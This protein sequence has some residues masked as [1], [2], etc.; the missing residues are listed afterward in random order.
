MGAYHTLDLEM[1]RKFTL[2]KHEWD[3]IALDRI[4]KIWFDT[5]L[6][7]SFVEHL[8]QEEVTGF[9]ISHSIPN[10]MLRLALINILTN[11]DKLGKFLIKQNCLNS[12]DFLV[13]MIT[14]NC[15]IF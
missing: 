2:G 15:I 3:S 4:G 8:F 5:V 13:V 7:A 11:L 1:N 12:S 14:L 10:Q 9:T 6:I